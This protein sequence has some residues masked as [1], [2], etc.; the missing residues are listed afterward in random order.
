MPFKHQSLSIVRKGHE[1]MT[2]KEYA[3][4]VK[5]PRFFNTDI[6]TQLN[7]AVNHAM[8]NSTTN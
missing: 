5:I 7:Q 2:V 4:R 3:I 1:L 8:T 6:G